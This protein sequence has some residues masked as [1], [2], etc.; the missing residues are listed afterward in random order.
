MA[1]K[2]MS[3]KKDGAD[4]KRENRYRSQFPDQETRPPDV[5]SDD[6]SL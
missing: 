4:P 3:Q 5:G 1:Q 2:A 6:V